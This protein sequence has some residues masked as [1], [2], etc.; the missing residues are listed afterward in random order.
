MASRPDR[1]KHVR[2]GGGVLLFRPM[3][4]I[5]AHGTISKWIAT[6]ESRDVDEESTR[7]GRACSGRL[8]AALAE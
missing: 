3:A 2:W 4:G 6:T 8:W 5:R 7:G 1:D